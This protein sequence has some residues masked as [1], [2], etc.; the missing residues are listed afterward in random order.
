MKK[1]ILFCLVFLGSYFGAQTIEPYLQAVT[2]NSVYVNW[3]ADTPDPVSLVEFGTD[4]SSLD[5]SSTGFYTTFSGVGS[6]HY[7]TVKLTGLQPN[8]KYYYRVKYG[9]NI[10]EILSFKTLPINGQAATSDGHIRFLVLGDNQLRYVD[11]FDR[12]V[13]AAKNKIAEKWGAANDPCDNLAM[14]VMVGD[15]VDTGTLDHYRNVH[16]KK[17]RALSGY[18]PIQTLVGNHE[19]Y[20]TLGIQAYEKHFIL[21]EMSYQGVFSGTEKY[22][23]RQAGNVLFICFDTEYTSTN[24]EEQLAWLKTILSKAK[25]DTTVEWIVSLGHR[26]YQAEQYVGDVSEWI[27]TRAFPELL[28]SEKFILHI[29]A[30]HHLYSRGQIKNHKVYNIISGG[31]AWD[32]YWGMSTEK[33]FPEI[34]KTLPNWIYQI[35]DIDVINKEFLVEAY[36][37]GSRN[38]EKNNVLVDSFHHKKNQ[39]KPNKPSIITDFSTPITQPADIFSSAYS[40]PSSEPINTSEFL[41]SKTEDFSNPVLELYRDYENLFGKLNGQEDESADINAGEDLM[42]LHLA[43]NQL[44]NGYYYVKT[45]HRD[46]NLE[47]SPW[48]EAKKFQII[49]STATEAPSIASNSDYYKLTDNIKI[50]FS[51]G[52]PSSSAWVGIYQPS[53]TPGALGSSNYSWAWEYTNGNIAGTISFENV[54]VAGGNVKYS[55]LPGRYYAALFKN[56]GYTILAQ[57]DLFYVGKKPVLSTDKTEYA[58]GETV[59]LSYENSDKL[60]TDKIA[61]FKVGKNYGNGLPGAEIPVT[62][63]SATVSV[64]NLNPGYYY[65]EYYVEN[66][67]MTIGNKVFFKVGNLVTNLM[68]NKPQ[69]ELGESI[70]ASWTDAPGIAKDWIGIYK[71]G[72]NPSTDSTEESGYSYTYFDGQPEGQKTISDDALPSE[73]GQYFAVIFTNDSYTEVSNRVYFE[74]N[75]T[76][77]GTKE[78]QTSDEIRMYP[79]PSRQGEP[80]IIESRFPISKVS[81]FDLSGKLL[82]ETNNVNNQKFSLINQNLPKGVYIIVIEGRKR[83]SYKLIIN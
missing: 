27:R 30:H 1:S 35:I 53:Q 26:P 5:V 29:G 15:Q 23:A 59:I 58:A 17:N 8:T 69:Y 10:G 6:Y 38:G 67:D 39:P 11:R 75:D 32:Q 68:L 21:D 31:T 79:N 50:T 36:S 62:A 16:F 54:G 81:L 49:G 24:G 63:S 82:Y 42:K 48:S 77:L 51:N 43:E 44:S 74:V 3:I 60:P 2:Q 41:V 72:D 34:Q 70:V 64:P 47:W 66:T 9:N 28:E 22:Y 18:L 45:R 4:P 14:T 12:L 20:G 80:T 56:S 46:Q 37:I 19:T 61:I 83:F 76:T 73:A 40:S 7:Y 25:D 33:D 55:F 52:S 13:A 65:A 71:K 78:T 57:S